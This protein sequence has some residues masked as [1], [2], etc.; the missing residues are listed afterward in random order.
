MYGYGLTESQLFT[1]Q[2]SYRAK[3]SVKVNHSRGVCHKRELQR[4]SVGQHQ[5]DRS[6]FYQEVSFILKELFMTTDCSVMTAD[7]PVVTA[8]CSVVTADSWL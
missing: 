1:Y 2:V 7:C 6:V 5:A 4:K 8:D 3:P